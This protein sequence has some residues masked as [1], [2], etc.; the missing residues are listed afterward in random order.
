[1]R[2]QKVQDYM[3]E[4]GF[5]FSYAE[6]S[7]LGS[8]DF[9]HRGISYHI[10]EFCENGEYGVETNVRTGGSQED[11]VGDYEEKLVKMLFERKQR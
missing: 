3:T 8:I 11:V 5:Q 10:W 4:L 9:E 6:E 2:L 7:G 1:M